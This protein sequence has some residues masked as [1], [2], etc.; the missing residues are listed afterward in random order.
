MHSDLHCSPITYIKFTLEHYKKL[1]S[2]GSYIE[3]AAVVIT[4]FVYSIQLPPLFNFII[5]EDYKKNYKFA[6]IK[7]HTSTM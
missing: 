3:Y 4:A 7:V 2:N 6:L 5:V 1:E